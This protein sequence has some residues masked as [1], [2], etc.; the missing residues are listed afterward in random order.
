MF[1][2]ILIAN[3]GE[4]ACRVIRTARRMGLLFAGI[5]LFAAVPAQAAFNP[6]EGPRPIAV[7]IEQNPWLMVIG[8]DVPRLAVY[9][10]GDVIFLK[11]TG[12]DDYEFRVAHLT[13]DE[14]RSLEQK[15]EPLFNAKLKNYYDLIPGVTDQT[16]SKLYVSRGD[17]TV[18]INAYGLDCDDGPELEQAF[19]KVKAGPPVVLFQ[20]HRALCNLD[21]T[22]NQ[23]WSPKY[24]EVMLWDY[25]HAIEPS[26]YWPKDWPNFTSERA[27]KRADSWSIFFDAGDLP[28]L[29]AFLKTQKE[30]GAVELDGK[31]WSVAYRSTFPGEPVWQKALL[32]VE[33]SE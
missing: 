23:K 24:V 7:L 6:F 19:S 2:K 33:D 30:K 18:A 13:P 21:F 10:N 8:S 4:I 31:K 14:L 26:I 5:A 29:S 22:Q 3:R 15:W 16:T 20:V 27:F 9:D 11:Q 12:K 28:K 1:S 25:S 32:P 17:Q